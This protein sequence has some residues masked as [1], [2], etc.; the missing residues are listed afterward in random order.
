MDSWGDNWDSKSVLLFNGWRALLADPTGGKLAGALFGANN[1]AGFQ[2]ASA[3]AFLV[4]A[5]IIVSFAPDLPNPLGVEASLDVSG[6]GGG[7]KK[8]SSSPKRK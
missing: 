4:I 7:G 3:I 8:R 2:A 5:P 1:N 6:G